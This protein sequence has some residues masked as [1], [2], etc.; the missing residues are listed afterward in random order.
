MVGRFEGV[1]QGRSR[2]R[3][4][5]DWAD[6]EAALINQAVAD[7]GAPAP[8]P[9]RTRTLTSPAFQDGYDLLREALRGPP[10]A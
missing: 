6:T 10:S 1:A 7:V 3:F 4:T 2:L 8:L 5:I 9:E